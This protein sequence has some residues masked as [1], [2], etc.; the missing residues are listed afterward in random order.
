VT[1]AFNQMPNSKVRLDEANL[2]PTKENLEHMLGTNDPGAGLYRI[3]VGEFGQFD[4]V[5]RISSSSIESG[6]TIFNNGVNNNFQ[7]AVRNGTTQVAQLDGAASGYIL[8]FNPTSNLPTDLLEA[9]GDISGTYFG[10]GHTELAENLAGVIDTASKSGVTGLRLIGHSQG[11]AITTSALRYA[12]DNGLNLSAVGSVHLHGAPINDLFVKNSLSRR[13]GINKA[14]FFT[15]AQFGDAV[16]NIF[17]ANFIS[18]PLSLPFSAIRIPHLFSHD[19]T[20]SPHTVPCFGGR[21]AFCSK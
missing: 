3:E 9:V 16:H 7:A 2:A 12:A 15:R 19:A 21:M 13:T 14:S 5:S 10:V 18:N 17:G 4:Q 6:E 8:N 11:A 1:E 20:L